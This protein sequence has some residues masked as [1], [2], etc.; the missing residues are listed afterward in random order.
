M[1][2]L[3][4]ALLLVM[5][6]PV[7]ARANGNIRGWCEAGNQP[8][9]TSG[10]SSSTLVQASFPQCTITVLIHGGGL[11]TLF[12]DN[13]GTPLANP[14]VAQ[15]NGQYLFYAA[16]N[17]YDVTL[18]C[19]SPC[20]PPTPTPFPVT[21]SD[22]V[23]GATGGGGTFSGSLA[24]TQIAF[25][26][27]ANAIGGSA[28][29]TYTTATGQI[30]SIATGS[31]PFN[32]LMSNAAAPSVTHGFRTTS[33]GVGSWRDSAGDFCTLNAPSIN[34]TC[35]DGSGNTSMLLNGSVASLSSGGGASF[36]VAASGN[37]MT[38]SSGSFTADN[39]PFAITWI[40]NNAGT[41]FNG[42]QITAVDSASAAGTQIFQVFGGAAGTTNLFKLSKAG[43]LAIAGVLTA[44]GVNFTEGAVPTGGAGSDNCGGVTSTHTLQCSFNNGTAFSMTQTI[45]SGTAALGTALIAS[46]A[47]ATV[48]TVAATGTLATDNVMADFNADPTGTTGYLPGAMLTVVKYPTSGNVNFKVCN[49]TASGITPAAVTL[50]W[51]VV[52]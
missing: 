14:F 22:I 48:V 15:T 38:A 50:N 8:V 9:I 27:G 46:N 29:L 40:N 18:T 23:L 19:V 31:L 7:V 21:F 30:T 52:R 17:R 20:V 42:M 10:L 5:L 28:N 3:L 6:T 26:T 45:A 35:G 44:T 24:N 13:V 1:R 49:N 41:L 25:G 51:R 36:Q 12:S 39:N 43:N 11:A 34:V 16:D 2:R 33:A 37:G 47:C 32:L 4:L